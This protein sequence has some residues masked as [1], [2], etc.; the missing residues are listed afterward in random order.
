MKNVNSNKQ[1]I[2]NHNFTHVHASLLHEIEQS[3][4]LIDARFW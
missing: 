2:K 4:V 1:P 3:S